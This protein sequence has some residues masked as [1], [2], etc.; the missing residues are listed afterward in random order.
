MS[1][2][3]I[4]SNRLPVQV[5]KSKEK[6]SFKESVG[7]LA[8]GL[9]S[10]HKKNS[11]WIGW[12][13]IAYD[14]ITE[15]QNINIE[16][17]LTKLK[18]IQVK[19]SSTEIKDFYFG[20]SNKCIWPLFHYFIDFSKFNNKEWEA[21]KNINKK[22]SK[23]IIEN[24]EYGGKIDEKNLYLEPTLIIDPDLNSEIMKEEIF[25]PILPILSYDNENDLNN[26]LKTNPSPLAFYIFSNNQKFI[27]NLIDSNKFGGCVVNDTLVH[28]INPNLPFGGIG[29]SGMGA[30][31][32]KFSF[33][34]FTHYKPV[35][36]KKS[37]IDIPFRYGPYP[38]SFKFIKKLLEKL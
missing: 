19:L 25:G 14:K 30:Y 12:A 7:G 32:G 29:E 16:K 23:H 13:G 26:I 3:I 9:K 24:I 2:N 6:Y 18:L 11:L 28:Y 21:Y 36:K 33:D 22:F 34:T 38:D 5:T 10:V 4:V 8:T 27:D 1:K 35:L 17:S 31:R 37:M 15:D 20:M